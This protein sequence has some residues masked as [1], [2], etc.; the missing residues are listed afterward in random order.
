MLILRCLQHH[1]LRTR[2]SSIFAISKRCLLVE[3]IGN[4]DTMMSQVR[5]KLTEIVGSSKQWGTKTIQLSGRLAKSQAE[6]PSRRMMDSYQEA[7]IPLGSNPD[8]RESYINFFNR[9]RFGRISEDL[10]TMAGLKTFSIQ[11]DRDILIRGH[12][13]WVG[14]TSIEV[15]MDVDQKTKNGGWEKQ[16]DAKFLMV[17]RNPQTKGKAYISPLELITEEERKLFVE[18]EANKAKRQQENEKSLLRTPP[19][20][21]ERRIIHDLFLCTLDDRAATFKHPVKPEGATWMEDTLLKNIHV[22]FPQER[23]L[24]NKI[25]GGFL[26]RQAFEMAWADA[27]LFSHSPPTAVAVDD[28]MFRKPVEVGSLLFMST[29]VVYTEGPYMQVKVHAE[30]VNPN[31]GEHETTNIFYYTFKCYAGDVPV[32]MPKSYSEYMM[33]IDG[34]R[35]FDD[36]SGKRSHRSE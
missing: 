26:M 11:P 32:V 7:C 23:N 28:I 2:H 21:Q 36:A 33:Y 15:S 29:Q 30:V 3:R 17:A 19:T 5:Q 27:C 25:F 34:K 24:Y 8:L 10:D 13:S 4:C 14:S 20:E 22:C 16:L 1:L 35:H 12:V 31:T 18:G 9:V 6:L